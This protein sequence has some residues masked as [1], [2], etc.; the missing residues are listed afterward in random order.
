[1][2]CVFAS[3]IVTDLFLHSLIIF[4]KMILFV[5]VFFCCTDYCYSFIV[6]LRFWS[7][8]LDVEIA[9]SFLPLF[10]NDCISPSF[11]PFTVLMI[12]VFVTFFL[13]TIFVSD[14]L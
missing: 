6:A 14:F 3:L 13:R 8:V 7:V 2:I 11:S 9:S 4:A 1:M 5:V 12:C 10:V